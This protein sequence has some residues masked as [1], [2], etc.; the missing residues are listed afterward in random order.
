VGVC[1]Q[2]LG[3]VVKGRS[4]EPEWAPGEE[5]YESVRIERGDAGVRVEKQDM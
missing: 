5:A 4:H 3:F 2:A 1:V